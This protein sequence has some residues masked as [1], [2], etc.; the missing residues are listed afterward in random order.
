MRAK[1]NP[2]QGHVWPKWGLCSSVNL[3]LIL[4]VV[5]SVRNFMGKHASEQTPAP[6]SP[7]SGL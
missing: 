1:E 3:N 5:C 6:G 7:S 2:R 4:A